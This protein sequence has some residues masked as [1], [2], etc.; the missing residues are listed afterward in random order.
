MPGSHRKT[1]RAPLSCTSCQSRK[2]KC[3]K[4]IPCQGCISRGAAADCKREVVL[5]RGRVRTADIPGSSPTIAELLLENARLA[6]LVS[7][8]QATESSYAPAVDLTEYYEKR[9]YEA[10]GRTCEPRTV[11]STNDIAF[12]TQDC[13][14]RFIEFADVWTSWVHFAFFFPEFH[15]EH[16]HFW[17]QG[18]SFLSADPLWLAVYFAVLASALGFMS[19]EDFAKSGAPLSSR[20]ALTRNWFS[21]ALFY[22]DKGEFLQ[23][24]HI[25]VVQAIV[26][27]GNVVSK[28]STYYIDTMSAN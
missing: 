16:E 9:L 4:N 6:E 27:L 13:S 15:H 24:S 8:S 11:A 23:Q 10:V 26:V 18:G 17:A 22:L 12:P 7:R 19:E 28:N 14:R 1:Q 20:S 5:V 25:R 2:V 3:S 21:T